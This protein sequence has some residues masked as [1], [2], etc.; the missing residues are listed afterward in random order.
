MKFQDI[1]ED[2][3][4]QMSLSSNTVKFVNKTTKKDSFNLF[5]WYTLIY[6]F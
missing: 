2:Q 3:K 4:Q 1:L 6:V 5:I